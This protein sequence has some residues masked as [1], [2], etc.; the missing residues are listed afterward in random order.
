M[1]T[2][3]YRIVRQEEITTPMRSRWFSTAI[4]MPFIF[5]GQ[6][7]P[8]SGT[9]VIPSPITNITG[10]YAY[11]RAFL[12]TFTALEE[13]TMERVGITGALRALEFGYRIRVVETFMI[14]W[15]VD[16]PRRAG[17]GPGHPAGP[18]P[19][20]PVPIPYRSALFVGFVIGSS[21]VV[22]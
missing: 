16:T 11:R 6:R 17:P 20:D 15:E 2:L 5:P 1:A 10:S 12:R 14:P 4:S 18:R 9:T 19:L 13:G 3:I 7:F 22:E 8:M 21:T